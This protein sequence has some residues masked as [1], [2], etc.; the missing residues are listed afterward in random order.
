MPQ[1]LALAKY[2][3]PTYGTGPFEIRDLKKNWITA[4][5][6]SLTLVA[7]PDYWQGNGH[8]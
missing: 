4:K 5:I 1:N 6:P 2:K 7:N 8:I 3:P